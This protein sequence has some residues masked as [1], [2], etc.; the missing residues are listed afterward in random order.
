MKLAL[1]ALVLA[2]GISASALAETDAGTEPAVARLPE[3]LGLTLSREEPMTITAQELE[4]SRD[5][6]GRERVLFRKQVRIVQGDL[7]LRCDFLEAIY[8]EGA[9]GRPRY[10]TAR[11]DV[12]MVQGDLEV[13]CTE[14]VFDDAACSAV[15]TSSSGPAILRRGDSVIEGEEIYFDLCTGLLKVK[16][17]QVRIPGGGGRREEATA[18][19]TGEP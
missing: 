11:G 6:Q 18:S 8:P 2:A 16:R 3:R 12:R 14:A 15:C 1:G 13:E 10:I 9:G 5:D 4:A 7:D 17:G 19:G